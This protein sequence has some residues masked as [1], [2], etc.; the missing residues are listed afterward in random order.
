MISDRWPKRSAMSL[1]LHAQGSSQR[2]SQQLDLNPPVRMLKTEARAILGIS[3]EASASKVEEVYRKRM[4]EI[5]RRLDAAR[6]RICR[7][8]V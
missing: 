7:N 4:G 3:G 5:R 2:T 6:G 1:F 8:C